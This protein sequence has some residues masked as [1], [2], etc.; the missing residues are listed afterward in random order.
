M[1]TWN[2][3]GVLTKMENYNHTYIAMY[4][5]ICIYIY[6]YIYI[7]IYIYIFIYIYISPLY[8]IQSPSS[9]VTSVASLRGCLTPALHLA[10]VD[11]SWP[12]LA[13]LEKLCRFQ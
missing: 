4:I 10:A 2:L 7:Y 3:E 1:Q 6:M 11:L 9:P 12:Q 13:E 8:P 5:Y